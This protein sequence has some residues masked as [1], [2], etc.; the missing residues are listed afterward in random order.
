MSPQ[1]LA[2]PGGAQLDRMQWVADPPADDTIDAILG[3]WTE[4]Q[5]AAR[6]DLLRRLHEI[7]SAW[8]DNASVLAWQPTPEQIRLGIGAPM[9]EYVKAAEPLPPWAERD[10]I[11]RGA[12]VFEKYGALSVTLLFCASLPECYVVPDL[13]SVLQATAQLLTNVD[14]RIR[15]T[16][17]VIFPVMMPG[18][19]TTPRGGGI[20]QILKVRLIHAMIRNLLLRGSPANAMAH[21]VAIPALPPIPNPSVPQLLHV[22]GWNLPVRRLPTNQ[23]ELAYTLLTF[24]YVFLR[25]MRDLGIAYTAEQEEDYLHTWNV[26]CHFIGVR[27]EMMANTMREAEAL[28]ALMQARGRDD[29]AKR[30]EKP[31]LRALLGKALMDA[32][33]KVTPDGP[34][35][36]FPV[37]MTRLLIGPESSRDLALGERASLL[38]RFLFAVLLGAIRLIDC[39]VRRVFPDFSMARLVTRA[40]GYRLI[41]GLI[42][43]QLLLPAELHAH[44][45]AL[46]ASWGDDPD[47]SSRM[48][49]VEDLVTT[50][51]AWKAL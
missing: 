15:A 7:V 21:G 44:V 42:L 5:T 19:L 29:W 28:F 36:A 14:H 8:T 27:R 50:K 37:L 39:V 51:G 35:K 45:V 31:D 2:I 41:C 3:P 18:G 34:F 46:V 25:G 1:I 26:A 24:N 22:H 16:G 30:P 38:A 20:A 32:L 12:K 13:A 4:P 9:L 47:A 23:E 6:L 17:A 11:A 33:K 10:R 40:I 48:N 43:P 49:F